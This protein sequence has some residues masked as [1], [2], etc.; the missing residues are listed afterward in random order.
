MKGPCPLGFYHDN[1]PGFYKLWLINQVKNYIIDVSIHMD[2]KY[3]ILGQKS[4][5]R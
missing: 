2:L 5:I 3:N 1:L 4:A